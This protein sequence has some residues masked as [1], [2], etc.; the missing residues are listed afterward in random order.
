MDVRRGREDVGLATNERGPQ[1]P[2]TLR[3]EWD[4]K[5]GHVERLHLPFQTVETINESR[6]SRERDHGALFGSQADEVVN[7]LAW[8]DNK[9]VASSLLSEY[10]GKVRLVYI[11][12]PFDTGT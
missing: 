9:L 5:P 2:M 10:A 8:G 6:A 3:L 12:P 4:D 1:P 11:D 7:V